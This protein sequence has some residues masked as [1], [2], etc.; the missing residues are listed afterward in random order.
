LKQ[1]LYTA[2]C[3]KDP[4][5]FLT[6][7]ATGSIIKRESSQDS[8]VF[9]YQCVL[10]TKDG[11][12]P[13]FQMVLA[14]HRALI[15]S[16]FLRNIIAR[17]LP[18]PRTVVTDFG[19]AL[20]IAVSDVFAKCVNFRDYL[21]K[22]YD[23]AILGNISMLPTC[24]LRLDVSHLIKMVA[25][26]KCLKGKEKMLVRVFNLRCISQAYLMDSFKEVEYLL[27]SLLIV[28]L[29]KTI[30]CT[31]DGKLLMS[32][33]RMQ[34]LNN[35]I[36][37]HINNEMETIINDNSDENQ[38]I[39]KLSIDDTNMNSH[40]ADWMEWSNSIL[41]SAKRIADESDNGNIINAC[42]NPEFVKQVK[43]RLL[44]YLPNMDGHNASIF[45]KIRRYCVFLF[46]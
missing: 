25:K 21:Q 37:D 44:P 20:L 9:L 43:T 41:D 46:S 6:I 31:V 28:A 26:W 42:Y 40:N 24:Y 36:K 3:K 4:E 7:D 34:H 33:I 14:D 27:E 32:D 8:P 11:S 35:I 10:V 17:N 16:F 5:E 38:E 29:S 18:I 22:C 1:L 15:I 19:W 23:A 45:Q 39:D 13:V 2:R 30:G 12:V